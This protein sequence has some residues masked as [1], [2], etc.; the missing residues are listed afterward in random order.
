MTSHGIHEV[1]MFMKVYQ[2][3]GQWWY[4]ID[5]S[6]PKRLDEDM[7]DTILQDM[8]LEKKL[9]DSYTPQFNNVKITIEAE[10][11][12]G[13]KHEWTKMSGEVAEQ[14]FKRFPGLVD[15]FW[16]DKP[17]KE[18]IGKYLNLKHHKPKGKY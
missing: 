16:R 17:R 15:T 6:D 8:H 1:F 18:K 5:D 3:S 12:A 7:R 9:S 4:V 13:T 14:L 10:S 11:T 2:K